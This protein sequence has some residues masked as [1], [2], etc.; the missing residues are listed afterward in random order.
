LRLAY[1]QIAGGKLREA[2]AT[3]AEL[4]AGPP[5]PRVDMI[6]AYLASRTGDWRALIASAERAV[7]KADELGARRIAALAWDEQG[8]AKL[9][10]G[11]LDGAA[12]A[13]D[14]AERRFT[15]T[16]DQSGIARVMFHRAQVVA[17]RD[18]NPAARELAAKALALYTQLDHRDGMAMTQVAMAMY[19][20]PDALDDAIAHYDAAAALYRKGNDPAGLT[21]VLL[22]EASVYYKL[23]DHGR[24]RT[25]LD[26]VLRTARTLGDS[27]TVAAAAINLGLVTLGE[28]DPP[29]A[30]LLLEEAEGAARALGDPA[31]VA[32]VD[33]G[34]GEV[35]RARG[36]VDAA[37]KR[38]DA[39]IALADTSSDPSPIEQARCAKARV[40]PS[41]DVASA[42]TQAA[43][44]LE[45]LG[46]IDDAVV[47]SW[48]VVRSRLATRDQKG[49]ASAL[50]HLAEL[51]AASPDKHTQQIARIAAGEVAGPAAAITDLEDIAKE[52][53]AMG[54]H[55][56]ALEAQ[57]GAGQLLRASGEE[58]IGDL[59]LATVEEAAS[60]RGMVALARRSAAARRR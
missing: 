37:V 57:F 1:A 20:P 23:G 40:E 13:L 17:A 47:L 9:N 27:S 22:N 5:H 21:N 14:E 46:S 18:G 32:Y 50:A 38:F 25:T 8:I 54:A 49:A 58:A 4:K 6:E 30:Q 52:A 41:G 16:G 59:Q 42:C 3:V 53:K 12:K 44:A 34:L 33:W 15:A 29:R 24:F 31:Y 28:A 55:E 2:Q 10:L 36:D 35:A 56:L 7:A 19:A 45:K 60:A 51:A 11:E 48:Q 39:V 43:A 26:E